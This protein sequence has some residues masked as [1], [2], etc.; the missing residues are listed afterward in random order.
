MFPTGIRNPRA[1]G[2]ART[3]YTDQGVHVI[4][5]AL[6]LH[7]LSGGAER[8]AAA[9]ADTLYTPPVAYSGKGVSAGLA[10]LENGGSLVPCWAKPAA[11][12]RG[13]MLRL[14]ETLGRR[15]TTPLRLA[16]GMRAYRTD[17]SE[18]AGDGK[19]VTEAAYAPYELIS[20][21]IVHG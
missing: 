8:N 5:L 10:N 19:A 16:E 7:G 4:R 15:G 18:G 17:L 20:L 13:W 2:A 12:G 21:R 11:D 14:H 6:C 9:L 1:D 3:L